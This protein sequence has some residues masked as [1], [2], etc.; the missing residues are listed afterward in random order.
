[1]VVVV[2]PV[3]EIQTAEIEEAL[4]AI[5]TATLQAIAEELGVSEATL[6]RYRR[7]AIIPIVR[8]PALA[9]ALGLSSRPK[10]AR[11]ADV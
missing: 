9:R 5:D 4:R 2:M 11:D 3:E 7:G 8:R 1:M 6:W 10:R